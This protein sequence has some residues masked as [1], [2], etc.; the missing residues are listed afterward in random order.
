MIQN[1]LKKFQGVRIDLIQNLRLRRIFEAAI[2]PHPEHAILPMSDFEIAI[3]VVALSWIRSDVIIVRVPA[4]VI[5]R[6]LDLI[7]IKRDPRDA[8]FAFIPVFDAVV[9]ECLEDRAHRLADAINGLSLRHH[10]VVLIQGFGVMLSQ[11][12][13]FLQD[14][15]LFAFGD[16]GSRPAIHTRR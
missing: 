13:H 15:L 6:Q 10:V 9:S 11:F 14:D 2:L 4:T 1:A 7:R 12:R 3:Q 16:S 8:A 5:L